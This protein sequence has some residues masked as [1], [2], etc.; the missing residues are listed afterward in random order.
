MTDLDLEKL[1]EQWRQQ[2][3]P[4]ELEELRRSAESARRRARWGQLIE[5]AAGIIVGI[6]VLALVLSN[7]QVDT[8]LIGAVAI[9]VLLISH[10]RQRRLRRIEL[11]SL[12]GGTEEMLEQSVARTEAQ[13]KWAR[14]SLIAWGPALIIGTLVAHLVQNRAGRQL[15]PE[16]VSGAEIR[17]VVIGVAV[18]SM[19]VMAL[20][21]LRMIR[22]AK[23]QLERLI[24]LREAYRRERMSSG[25]L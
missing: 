20:H 13:L 11:Q 25:P 22:K 6:V 10:S 18:L 21:L 14:F 3:D 9:L 8:A 12:S 5:I 24:Q 17:L 4:A 2:P 1:G 15:W 7:P 19:A 16:T 23:R